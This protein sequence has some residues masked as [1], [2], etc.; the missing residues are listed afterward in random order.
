M[1]F[2]TVHTAVSL[3]THTAAP[4]GRSCARLAV[5]TKI[6]ACAE[7]NNKATRRDALLAATFGAVLGVGPP[8]FAS[9]FSGAQSD[10]EAR[11]AALLAAARAK[12]LGEEVPDIPDY[13]PVGGLS[14]SAESKPEPTSKPKPAAAPQKASGGG[15]GGGA[16]P[17]KKAE[18]S[19]PESKKM[20]AEE[21]Q[22]QKE[23]RMAAIRAKALE[24]AGQSPDS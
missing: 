15:G 12:A 1:A 16:K 6:V 4:R 9:S 14:L 24:Q 7:T 5:P 13:T 19:A 23:E 10:R 22:K 2:A 21:R 18:E 20:S 11:K 3:R 17:Q 8:A